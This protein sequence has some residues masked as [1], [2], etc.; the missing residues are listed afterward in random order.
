MVLSGIDRLP[1]IVGSLRIIRFGGLLGGVACFTQIVIEQAGSDLVSHNGL[2][3]R[4]ANKNFPATMVCRPEHCSGSDLW[5]EDRWNGLRL[6]P[7]PALD[8]RELGR[9]ERGHVDHCQPN[10]A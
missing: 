1:K 9:V 8:L 10:V 4:A 3:G 5:R 2:E 6:M 7:K